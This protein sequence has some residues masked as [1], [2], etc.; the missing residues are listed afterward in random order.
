MLLSF[1]KKEI[2]QEDLKRETER[3]RRI[4]KI[5][6]DSSTTL[7]SSSTVMAVVVNGLSPVDEEIDN[8]DDDYLEVFYQQQKIFLNLPFYFYNFLC[9]K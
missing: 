3:E 4:M 5:V 2:T 1:H 9:H 7:S 8:I 6:E